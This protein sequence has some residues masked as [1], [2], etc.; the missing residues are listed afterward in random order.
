MNLL[1][2]SCYE[3]EKYMRI[4]TETAKKLYYYVQ[5]AGHFVCKQDFHIKRS[6][7]S[8]YLLIYTGSGSGTLK[9]KS[10]EYRISSNSFCFLDCR[11]PHE[12]I[13]QAAPWGFKFIHFYGNLSSQYYDYITQLYASPVFTC[14][15]ADTAVLFDKVLQ[16]VRNSDEEAVCSE[17]IYR[18][19][20][21]IISSFNHS[22]ASF[23]FRTVMDYIAENYMEYIDVNDIAQ[24][25][26]LSRSYF[27]TKFTETAGISPYAYLKQCRISAAKGLLINSS[28]TIQDISERCG[29]NS[30]AAF[31]RAFKSS[32]GVTQMHYRRQTGADSSTV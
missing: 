31:I 20:T 22:D 28:Y 19:L 25:F 27:T 24:K 14:L 5:W 29:F 23:S 2:E 13:T 6:H 10:R 7:F 21:E 18:I 30:C 15:N 9:Y 3:K 11:I 12:Y 8:S 16:N 4:P 17:Y 32:I 26:N 1:K